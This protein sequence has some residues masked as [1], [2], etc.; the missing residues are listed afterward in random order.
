MAKGNLPLC[1]CGSGKLYEECCYT[2]KG[3]D[4]EPLF[5]NGALFNDGEKWHPIPNIR[6][7][8]TV[9][10]EILDKY[11]EKAI[12]LL[13][14]ST[15][16]TKYHKSFVDSFGVFY[17]S[18]EN[19]LNAIERP[20]GKG[21]YFQMDSVEIR[22]CWQD[23]LFHGR[24]LLD[25]LGLHCRSTLLLKQDIGGLNKKKYDL[26]LKTL[27]K[28]GEKEQ[29]YYQI[30][31][32]LDSVKEN[33]ITFIE[34]RDKEKL[35]QNTITSFPVIDMDKGLIKDGIIVL[36]GFNYDMVKFIRNSYASIY[37]L[38]KVLLGQLD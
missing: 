26:L 6:F 28:L 24:I 38:T 22:K 21:A 29:R 37:N 4:G 18:Y 19:L 25:F 31:S 35:F 11:R 16:N 5:F 34:F 36:H 10:G 30:K 8:M 14:H 13:S 32:L 17:Q 12:D 27:E 2:K 3:I 23:Y 33:I 15:L 7:E 1:P 20:G 9:I